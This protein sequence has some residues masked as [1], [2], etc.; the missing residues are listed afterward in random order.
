MATRQEKWEDENKGWLDIGI[1]T[2][3]D[4]FEQTPPDESYVGITEDIRKIKN[5]EDAEIKDYYDVLR[6]INEY[7]QKTPD[8]G[9]GFSI[10]GLGTPWG[11]MMQG[12]RMGL[13]DEMDKK[14]PDRGKGDYNFTEYQ[15]AYAEKDINKRNKM[16][17]RLRKQFDPDLK[18][19]HLE[20]DRPF[21][22]SDVT[23]AIKRGKEKIPQAGYEGPFGKIGEYFSKNADARDKLFDYMTS[24]GRELV[25]P[26]EP[27]KEAAGALVPTLVRGMEAGEKKYAA[28]KLAETEMLLKR[29][30]AAQKANP[31][32][33]FTS[34]M[35]ELRAQ[36]WSA[37]IDPDTAEGIAW[38]G[39]QLTQIGIGEGA[40]Q[41]T[42]SLANAQ[43]QLMLI[44]DPEKKEEQQKLIDKLNAQ[45]MALI[46]QGT[47]GES[48]YIPYNP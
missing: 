10:D 30:E 35:K 34:K 23:K 44:T 42:A 31:L 32:Q 5:N 45:L 26:I 29:A 14:F 17:D 21:L 20:G 48:N 11:N 22:E 40:A 1:D 4:F 38:M 7:H 28:E 33:Y 27:G 47:A 6:R 19:P 37:N 18:S 16:L 43:E 25:K 9:P 3:T 15:K 39:Q 46:T 13:L 12:Q 2:I 8:K 36:A 24:V 41:L